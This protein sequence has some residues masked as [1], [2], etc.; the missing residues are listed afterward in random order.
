MMAGHDSIVGPALA[1][2]LGG[3]EDEQEQAADIMDGLS[4]YADFYQSAAAQGVDLPA[5]PPGNWKTSTWEGYR[6]A[7]HAGPGARVRLDRKKTST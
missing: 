2:L 7:W 3:E 4:A 1:V 5:D 6:L